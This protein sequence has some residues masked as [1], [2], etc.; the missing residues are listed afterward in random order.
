M[1]ARGLDEDRIDLTMKETIVL[2]AV[3]GRPRD[4]MHI[5]KFYL[6]MEGCE[7][8]LGTLFP[9][10]Q[11]LWRAGFIDRV[12]PT[13]GPNRGRR[14]VPYGI[15]ESGRMVLRWELDRLEGLVTQGRERLVG[16]G[17]NLLD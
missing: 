14:R 15:T 6:G 13:D 3:A 2:I 1:S 11:R 4:G 8:S 5:A 10:L 17:K 9:L 12:E 16:T 7:I